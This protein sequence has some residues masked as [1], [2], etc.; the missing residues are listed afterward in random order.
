MNKSL[1]LQVHICVFC[2][3]FQFYTYNS[4]SIANC[5]LPDEIG[6]KAID[7]TIWI[8]NK[9]KMESKNKKI[10]YVLNYD[11]KRF[12]EII[13]FFLL[14]LNSIMWHRN[15]SEQINSKRTSTLY[16]VHHHHRWKWWWHK[17]IS[18]VLFTDN[19]IISAFLVLW[20]Q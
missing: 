18:W 1:L 12:N 15:T 16:S 19:A 13:E 6:S 14:I 9:T 2:A 5:Y 8:M 11:N 3:L 17:L 10:N 7:K 20:S 4:I